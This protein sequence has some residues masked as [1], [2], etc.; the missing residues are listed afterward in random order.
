MFEFFITSALKS[1]AVLAAAFAITFLLRRRSAAAR[2]L[3]WTAAAAAIIA[4][5]LLSI[6]LPALRTSMPAALLLSDTGLTFQTDASPARV[7]VTSPQR[8]MLRGSAAAPW[9]SAQRPDWKSS[10]MLV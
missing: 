7:A 5:P 4:L 10:I 6:S 1:S 9:F 2:H 8:A 3:V